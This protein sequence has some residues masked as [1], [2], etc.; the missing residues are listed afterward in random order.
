MEEHPP[1]RYLIEEINRLNG[2]FTLYAV[3]WALI[4]LINIE[5]KSR[6]LTGFLFAFA[7][8]VNLLLFIYFSG[9]LSAPSI[10]EEFT[11]AEMLQIKRTSQALNR[12]YM[13][14]A[15]LSA[16][17]LILFIPI[18]HQPVY[19]TPLFLGIT[20]ILF[21]AHRCYLQILGERWIAPVLF[22]MVLVLLVL[23]S[24]YIN[25]Y[26][27]GGFSGATIVWYAC[28]DRHMLVHTWLQE[29]EQDEIPPQ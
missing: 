12:V 25:W 22:L 3:P 18:L 10:K 24:Q 6:Q 4:G 27:W 28:L 16:I 9:E 11:M 14:L 7:F 15:F 17:A 23:G 8:I 2:F 21:I 19:L 1:R 5:I 26:S 20:G 29:Q 13:L